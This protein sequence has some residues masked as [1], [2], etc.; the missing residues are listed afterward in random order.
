MPFFESFLHAPE[1]PDEERTQMSSSSTD[2][3][4][5]DQSKRDKSKC[6]RRYVESGEVSGAMRFCFMIE[7][8]YI[9]PCRL[10]EK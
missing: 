9:R 5:S 6:L 10:G 4:Q 3:R 2:T 1:H 8:G 7:L